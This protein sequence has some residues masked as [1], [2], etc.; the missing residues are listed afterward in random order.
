MTEK[1]VTEAV[2][3]KK[4]QETSDWNETLLGEL[5]KLN[6]RLYKDNGNLSVQTRLDRQE[7]FLKAL[8]KLIWMVGSVLLLNVV[9]TGIAF[10]ILLI[11]HVF[12]Q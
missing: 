5:H 12:T 7:Q 9:G 10:G 3:E 11:K 8:G 4:H 6:D 2:C 1:Y